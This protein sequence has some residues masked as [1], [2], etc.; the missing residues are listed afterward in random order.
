[1]GARARCEHAVPRVKVGG[2]TVDKA[3]TRAPIF[4]GYTVRRIRTFSGQ[5]SLEKSPLWFLL[6]ETHDPLVR[7]SG[8]RCLQERQKF[9]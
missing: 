9:P 5:P 4:I 3:I 2:M 8:F 1:M 7:D 6:R